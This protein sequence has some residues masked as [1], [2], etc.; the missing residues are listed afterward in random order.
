[1]DKALKIIMGLLVVLAGLYSY[2]Q[3]P[4]NLAALWT[5]IKGSVGLIVILIGL[6]LILVGF[7]E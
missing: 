5:I 6:L 1:M 2:I 7:T 3:W 4:G